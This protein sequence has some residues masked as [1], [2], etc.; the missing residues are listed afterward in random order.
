VLSGRRVLGTTKVILGWGC[1]RGSGAEHKAEDNNRTLRNGAS[2]DCVVGDLRPTKR[3]RASRPR[4]MR[5]MSFSQKARRCR[6]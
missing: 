6:I 3:G 1:V 5:L 2:S 4:V